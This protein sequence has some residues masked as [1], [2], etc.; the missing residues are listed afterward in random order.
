[1]GKSAFIFIVCIVISIFGASTALSYYNSNPTLAQQILGLTV[2][3]NIAGIIGL[4]LVNKR[5]P[6]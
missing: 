3:L 2:I 1:M 4:I 5:N 6:S